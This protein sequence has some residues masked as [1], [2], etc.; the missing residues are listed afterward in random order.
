MLNGAR[1]A[2]ENDLSMW[3]GQ[4][5][6]QAIELEVHGGRLHSQYLS[7]SPNQGTH[8][9]SGEKQVCS[10]RKCLHEHNPSFAKSSA[11]FHQPNIFRTKED[12]VFL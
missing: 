10:E 4:L 6:A 12:P 1:Y 2:T 9:N 5:Q 11:F 3:T 7:A 8:D